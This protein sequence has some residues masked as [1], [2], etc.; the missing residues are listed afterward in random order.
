M[1]LHLI[2]LAII[3]GICISVSACQYSRYLGSKAEQHQ[4][5]ACQIKTELCGVEYKNGDHV[6][7]EVN[8]GS[9]NTYHVKGEVK[10]HWISKGV[11]EYVTFYVLFMD[12]EKVIYERKIK[13]RRKSTFEFD[14]QLD[15]EIKTSTIAKLTLWERT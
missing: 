9:D 12:A 6:Y 7:Y 10:I 8:K 4:R 5:L 3:A 14:F 11:S 2:K 1:V 13:T 15:K